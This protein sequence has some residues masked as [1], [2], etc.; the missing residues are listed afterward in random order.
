[1]AIPPAPTQVGAIASDASV[2]L[3]WSDGPTTAQ[4]TGHIITGSDG[5][6]RSVGPDLRTQVTGLVNGRAY[7]FT[8]A[9]VSSVGQGPPSA[10]SVP[11]MPQP[12][13]P[14]NRWVQTTPMPTA[15]ERAVAVRLRDGRVLVVGGTGQGP[16]GPTLSVC[17][18]YD[19]ATTNWTAAQA[20]GAMGSD[21]GVTLLTDGQV[22]RT[23]GFTAPITPLA[24]TELFAPA[25]GQWT[26][27]AAMTSARFGHTA[28]LLTDGRVLVAGGLAPA[29]AG[30]TTLASAELYDPATGQWST[31]GSLATARAHHSATRLLDGRV[32]VAGGSAGQS[33]FTSAELYDPAGGSWSPTGAMSITRQNDDVCCPGVALLPSGDVLVAGGAGPTGVLSSSEVYRVA[34][35]SWA[36][37]GDLVFGRDA[38]FTLTPL[39]DGRVLVAGGRDDWGPLA[40]AELYDEAT[41]AWTRT[42][43]MHLARMSPGTALLADGRVLLVGGAVFQPAFGVSATAETFS[44]T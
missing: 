7:S 17:E 34:T 29:P 15:R 18:V 44:P 39:L 5:Q 1:M 28:V 41:G 13:A 43:D 10:P 30:L 23:G 38:G 27:G 42:N 32:L 37:T 20:I 35:G 16:N 14:Q 2:R 21:F 6:I 4:V 11:V 12:P 25:T 22:L 19:P 33:G 31:T 36:A 26:A 3:T 40:Y 9:A 24:S 8:V